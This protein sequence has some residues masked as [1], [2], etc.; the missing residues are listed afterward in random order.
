MWLMALASSGS[1]LEKQ[2]LSATCLALLNQDLHLARSAGD[3]ITSKLRSPEYRFL[4]SSLEDCDS[5]DLGWGP[6]IYVSKKLPGIADSTH[7]GT[8]L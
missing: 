1:W 3:L 5:L 4:V 6:I 7:S 2:K 8:T